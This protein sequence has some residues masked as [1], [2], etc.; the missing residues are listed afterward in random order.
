MQK[1]MVRQCA[2]GY[3]MGTFVLKMHANILVLTANLDRD[4]ECDCD[5]ALTVT[6]CGKDLCQ[7]VEKY[8]KK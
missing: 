6:N 8:A 7:H 1:D 2:V 4:H 3:L 5:W